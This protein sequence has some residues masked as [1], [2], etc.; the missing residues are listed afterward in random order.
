MRYSCYKCEKIN[1]NLLNRQGSLSDNDLISIDQRL[2]PN[3]PINNNN[4]NSS[5]NECQNIINNYNSKSFEG[6]C[7]SRN[8]NDFKTK[9]PLVEKPGD[10]ICINCHNLN[11]SFRTKCNRCHLAKKQQ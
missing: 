11:F 6:C 4:I 1:I 9:K 8:N 10:W 3:L 7:G 2:Y 5:T